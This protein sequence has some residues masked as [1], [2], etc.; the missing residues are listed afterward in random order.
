MLARPAVVQADGQ[1]IDITIPGGYLETHVSVKLYRD[2]VD[3]R[4][5]RMNFA[6]AE[7][8][9]NAEEVFVQHTSIAEPTAIG[10]DADEVNVGNCR[11]GLRAEANQEPAKAPVL[12][13]DETRRPE[14]LEEQTRQQATHRPATPPVIDDRRDGGVVGEFERP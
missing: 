9:R 7:V 2:L 6:T 12:L 4:S 5:N 11:I 13:Q 3:R 10:I 14:M 1:A 8:A